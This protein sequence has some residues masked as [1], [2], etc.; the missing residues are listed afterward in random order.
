MDKIKKF[1]HNTDLGLLIFRLFVGLAMAFAHGLGK[2]PPPDKLVEGL[3][4]MGLPMPGI[5]SW[6][7]AIAEF[8]GGLF[9]ALGICTR[10]SAAILGFTMFVAGFVV[11]AADPFQVKELAF[12]YLASC[13]L[14]I[15][16]GAGKYSL[17][18]KI[19]KK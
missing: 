2:L 18:S 19:C 8:G 12:F 1:V 17:D 10:F 13:V 14:L 3:T 4:A 6:V 11:H 7:V 5:M 16:T 15:F 9:I